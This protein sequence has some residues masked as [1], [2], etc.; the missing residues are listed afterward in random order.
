MTASAKLAPTTAMVVD[1]HADS[2]ALFR[3]LLEARGYRVAEAVDG[4]AAQVV[5]PDLILLDLNMPR[6]DGLEAAERIRELKEECQGVVIIAVT[7]YDTYGI[8]EATL[9]AGCDAYLRKPVEMGELER[10]IDRLLPVG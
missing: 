6:M 7:A 3:R 5:C 9:E 1:D 4:E 10:E 2:R 8:R